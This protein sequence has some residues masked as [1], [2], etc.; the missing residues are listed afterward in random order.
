MDELRDKLCQTH[1]WISWH[2]LWIWKWLSSSQFSWLLWGDSDWSTKSRTIS[3]DHH[4][5]FD[6]NV[7]ICIDSFL[8]FF[9]EFF[10]FLWVKNDSSKQ[11]RT[12]PISIYIWYRT[13]LNPWIKLFGSERP[14]VCY[15]RLCHDALVCNF[16][17]NETVECH[18][19]P[20]TN[21]IIQYSLYTSYTPFSSPILQ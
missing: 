9:G 15:V 21:N 2:S 3:I 13:G 7:P 1:H 19:S 4:H 20:D 17:Y 16:L 12:H 5:R 11:C 10:C 14:G 18:A 6:F 8:L